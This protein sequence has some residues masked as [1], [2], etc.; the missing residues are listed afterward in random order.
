MRFM[1]H[2]S[3]TLLLLLA[4]GLAACTPPTPPVG[5]S[6]IYPLQ[7][8]DSFGR[9]VV[10]ELEPATIV[11]LAPSA[12]EILFAL[13][14]GDRLVGVTD[15]CN[16]P[17]EALAIE[18]MGGYQGVETE[19]IVA[20][21]PGLIIADSQTTKESVEQL[22]GF[23]LPVLALKADT[24]EDVYRHVELIGKAANVKEKAQEL[25]Q[26]MKERLQAISAKIEEIPEDERPQVFYEVWNEPLC[27]A[28]ANTFIN[29]IVAGAGGRNVMADAASDWPQV[30][31]ETL[32]EK[33]PAFVILGHE[34]QTEE[35]TL[36]RSNWH[37]IEAIQ[38]K[39]VYA[40]DPDIF[41]R[42]GPRLVDAAEELAKIFYPNLFK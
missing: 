8:T 33:N 21:N 2:L 15:N 1:K 12:T 28:G 13:G 9:E 17:E 38:K 27:S 3:L 39:Q 24:L 41:N 35:E 5:E 7:L 19:M 10:L 42:P 14:L 6:D 18:K 20:A 40:V 36:Q 25:V 11:S 34:G 26:N 29:H 31:L 22:A 16:Y 23:G 32:I 37:T 4:T 30:D